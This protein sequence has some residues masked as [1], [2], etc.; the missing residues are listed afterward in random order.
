MIQQ[1]PITKSAFIFFVVLM[2]GVSA[3]HIRALLWDDPYC[4]TFSKDG[5]CCVKCSYHYW[6]DKWGRCQPVSDWCK[7][8][9]DKNGCCTS[10]FPGY[11]NPVNGVCAS[12]PPV[13]S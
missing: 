8:W 11:G 6:M 9:N 1:K 2:A 7:T 5:K 12:A 13:G 3:G 10:C 4:N